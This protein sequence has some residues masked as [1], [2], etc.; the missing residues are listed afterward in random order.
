MSGRI[1]QVQK[2]VI[3]KNSGVRKNFSSLKNGYQ[4]FDVRENFPYRENSIRNL[5]LEKI[6]QVELHVSIKN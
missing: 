2:V 4:K 5:V 1:L 6:F 3:I